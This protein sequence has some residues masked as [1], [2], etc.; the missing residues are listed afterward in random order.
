MKKFMEILKGLLSFI[1][2]LCMALLIMWGLKTYAAR[3][4]EKEV[5]ALEKKIEKYEQQEK[6]DEIRKKEIE[7]QLLDPKIIQEKLQSVSKIICLESKARYKNYIKE[8]K[9]LG[10]RELYI[11]TQYKF[12]VSMDLSN[13]KYEVIRGDN[14][15]YG[16]KVVVTV[17]KD[18]LKIE[19]VERIVTDKDIQHDSSLLVKDYNPKDVNQVYKIAK[20]QVKTKLEEDR[21]VFYK[22]HENLKGELSKI[23]MGLGFRN[24]EFTE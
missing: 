14:I 7:K 12:G 16:E 9:L 1:L 21:E 6:Q 11:D 22:A 23:I 10:D 8:D 18:K 3:G 24:V 5:A 20:Q 13:I 17:L 19:Y 4:E 15:I 2:V